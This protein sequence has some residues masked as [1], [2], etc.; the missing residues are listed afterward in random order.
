MAHGLVVGTTEGGPE[1]AAG[2]VPHLRGE[3]PGNEE[4]GGQSLH[5]LN[6]PLLDSGW[7]LPGDEQM[8][9]TLK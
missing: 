1:S 5:V 3:L 8:W 6:V 9:A 7:T 2:R 4:P